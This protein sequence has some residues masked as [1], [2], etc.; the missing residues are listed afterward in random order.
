MATPQIHT[1]RNTLSLHDALPICLDKACISFSIASHKAD[2]TPAALFLLE[3]SG[4]LFQAEHLRQQII[5]QKQTIVKAKSKVKA[6][7]VSKS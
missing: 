4:T 2:V 6:K 3:L 5:Q 1:H 7:L